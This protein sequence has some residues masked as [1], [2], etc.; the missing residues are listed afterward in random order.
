MFGVLLPCVCDATTTTRFA[1]VCHLL[2]GTDA[3]LLPLFASKGYYS[4]PYFRP[5]SWSRQAAAGPLRCSL[6]R[7]TNRSCCGERMCNLDAFIPWHKYIS[8]CCDSLTNISGLWCFWWPFLLHFIST[9][10]AW[11]YLRWYYCCSIHCCLR[12]QQQNTER[13]FIRKSSVKV[14]RTLIFSLLLGSAHSKVDRV[15]FLTQWAAFAFWHLYTQWLPG[16]ARSDGVV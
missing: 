9:G 8:M 2:I 16:V 4:P 3:E 10:L 11:H 15:K 7:S 13:F 5:S 6:Q 12:L 1:F 14:H